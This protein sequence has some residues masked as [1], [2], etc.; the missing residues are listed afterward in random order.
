[1]DVME[2]VVL[3][4]AHLFGRKYMPAAVVKCEQK[5]SQSKVRFDTKR[6]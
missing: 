5:F 1:M 6:H 2:K 4:L 3:V